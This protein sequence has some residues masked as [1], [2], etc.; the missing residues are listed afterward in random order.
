MMADS[1]MINFP[2]FIHPLQILSVA[3]SVTGL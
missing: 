1:V 2:P 3:A